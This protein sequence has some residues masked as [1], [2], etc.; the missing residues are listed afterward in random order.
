M[1]DIPVQFYFKGLKGFI[2][3]EKISEELTDK[4]DKLEKCP[5]GNILDLHYFDFQK[6]IK[7]LLIDLSFEPESH[8]NKT[9]RNTKYVIHFD[10][11][12][13]IWNYD[14]KQVTSCLKSLSGHQN[15]VWTMIFLQ[16]DNTLVSG[17]LDRVI[18]LWNS[19]SGECFKTIKGHT[20]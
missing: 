1:S 19:T 20:N 2:T 17:G 10:K 16:D 4:I 18:K 14:R 9:S 12:I 8:N 15:M 11:F 5:K 6:R 13:K 7:Q 3:T